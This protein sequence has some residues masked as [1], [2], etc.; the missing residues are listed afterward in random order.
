M[1]KARAEKQTEEVETRE[2]STR[3][4]SVTQQKDPPVAPTASA[5]STR[6]PTK[7]TLQETSK[8]TSNLPSISS[9]STEPGLTASESKKRPFPPPISDKKPSISTQ[10][11]NM[12]E[13]QLKRRTTGVLTGGSAKSATQESVRLFS[14]D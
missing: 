14:C 13:D 1:R 3:G 5:S 4:N 11:L 6:R 9:T 10:S 8:S 7:S 12:S 2:S